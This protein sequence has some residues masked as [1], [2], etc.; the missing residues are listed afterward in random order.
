MK[1]I[2]SLSY[3][4]CLILFFILPQLL[5]AQCD[6]SLEDKQNSI[7]YQFR[8]KNRCEGM[9]ASEVSSG[10]LDIVGVTLGK[11]KF[12]FDAKE[13]LIVSSAVV[14]DQSLKV[15]AV[16]IPLKTYYRMD[17]EISPN[18]ELEWPVGAVLYRQEL[19]HKKIGVF[20]WTGSESEKT[21][22]PLTV[23][24]T[25]LTTPEDSTVYV[26]LRA[27]VNVMKVRWRFAD[28]LASGNCGKAEKW[29]YSRRNEYSSGDRIVIK[30]PVSYK[31]MVCIDVRADLIKG[32]DTL[33]HEAKILLN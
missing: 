30:V 18:G 3:I 28:A 21:Y 32:N 12:K 29:E 8:S 9:Y 11:F 4:I 13:R 24:S 23:K 7:G 1:K 22:V 2:L 5:Y 33:S 20:G 15:R 14:R 16:G 31:E 10:S 25:L 27:S 17:A 19:T 26:Y 6:P